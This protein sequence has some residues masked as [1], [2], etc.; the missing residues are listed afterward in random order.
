[1]SIDM[2]ISRQE[3]DANPDKN[4]Y[5]VL[6]C[7]HNRKKQILQRRKEDHKMDSFKHITEWRLLKGSHKFSGPEGGTCIN[8]AAIIA[9]GFK[10]KEVHSAKDCPPCFSLPIAAYAIKLNDSMP[11]DMRQELLIPFVTRLA[12]TADTPEIE[13]KR[14]HFMVIAGVNRIS[15]LLCE[16][17]KRPDLAQECRDAKTIADCRA[18]APKIRKAAAAAADAYAYA[19]ADAAAAADADAAAAAAAAAAADAYASAYAAAYAAA[20]AD[21]SAYAAAYASADASA[22]RKEIFTIACEIL[23]GAILLGKHTELEVCD[24]APRLE[25]AKAERT[26]ISA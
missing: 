19:S 16:K 25:K 24:V 12:G 6:C 3:L 17:I 7:N 26:K 22:A 18:V 20:A 4:R 21:A 11:D 2:F 1:M 13:L 15:A 8:E 10:Y 5:Q 9:A 23:D 14:G